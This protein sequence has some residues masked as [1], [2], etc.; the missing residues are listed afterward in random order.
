MS[1]TV[2]AATTPAAR[3]RHDPYGEG[4]VEARG[5][6]VASVRPPPGTLYLGLWGSVGFTPFPA[7]EHGGYAGA[8]AR[9]GGERAPR[10]D[11][12]VVPLE[13]ATGPSPPDAL[14]DGATFPERFPVAYAGDGDGGD[15][16]SAPAADRVGRGAE[17]EDDDSGRFLPGRDDAA[18]SSSDDAAEEP[19][20]VRVFLGQLP[21]NLSAAMVNW[22]CYTFGGRHTLV[23]ID[24]ITK[25]QNTNGARLPTG[26]A[27]AFGSPKGVAAL[28]TRI[29]RKVLVDTTGVWHAR[30]ATEL[31]ALRGYVEMLQRHPELRASNRP[32]D[33]VAVQL[34]TSTYHSRKHAAVA[35]VGWAAAKAPG[36]GRA[37]TEGGADEGGASH[38]AVAAPWSQWTGIAEA[39]A[40]EGAHSLALRERRAAAAGTR[41]AL[42]EAAAAAGQRH[43][44]IAEAHEALRAARAPLLLE[45]A[46][47][48]QRALAVAEYHAAHRGE[49]DAVAVDA[50]AAGQRHMATL[51]YHAAHRDERHTLGLEAAARG[52][53]RQQSKQVQREA[54]ELCGHRAAVRAA[55]VAVGYEAAVVGARRLG[56]PPPPPYPGYH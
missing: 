45:A 48:G 12:P 50:A 36:R 23:H 21:Y 49:H 7:D 30:N 37:A 43:L 34:S 52:A 44:R 31:A 46:A 42:A 54:A 10:A 20:L 18:S 15:H 41:R 16:H 26:C 6:P 17:A 55:R 3:F 35:A 27:H 22:L 33:L 39:A 4:R 25:R 19:A 11:A 51:A 32:Y 14:D 56:I 2:I 53:S 24:P 29:H 5:P 13:V 1:A 38:A 40:A 8:I 28:V 9:H 47:L